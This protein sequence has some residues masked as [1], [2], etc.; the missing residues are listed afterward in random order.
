MLKKAFEQEL[1]HLPDVLA[2]PGES[3][4]RTEASTSAAVKL[5]RFRGSMSTPVPRKSGRQDARQDHQQDNQGRVL[6]QDPAS[7]SP[8]KLIKS[9]VKVES[10]GGTILFDREAGYVVG[11]P[12]RSSA[13][14]VTT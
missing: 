3:W 2:R 14:R 4:E 7:E 8:F 12:R 11:E 13:S 9:D 6:K 1:R 5:S 10:S